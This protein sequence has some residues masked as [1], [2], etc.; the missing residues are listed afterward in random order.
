MKRDTILFGFETTFSL[1]VS[2][3]SGTLLRD[4]RHDACVIANEAIIPAGDIDRLN[5]PPRTKFASVKIDFG[6]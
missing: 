4:Q 1:L 2:T 3:K 6:C 5:L